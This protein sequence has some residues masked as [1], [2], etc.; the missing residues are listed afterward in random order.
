MTTRGLCRWIALAL[1]ACLA[2]GVRGNSIRSSTSF[3][4]P[5]FGSSNSL[6]LTT[7]VTD[8][9]DLHFATVLAGSPPLDAIAIK[10]H[11]SRC[12]R[13][14]P[15][16]SCPTQD[17][18]PA[19]ASTV[20]VRRAQKV[21]R[22]IRGLRPNSTYDVY[23]VAEVPQSNGVFGSVLNVRGTTTHPEPPSV[24]TT[25]AVAANGSAHAV[26]VDVSLKS[27]GVV[28][29]ALVPSRDEL[30]SRLAPR[31]VVNRERGNGVISVP[32]Q[33]VTWDDLALRDVT[34]D[35]L[36]S[37]TDYDL[38]VVTEAEGNG[39]VFSEV[40]HHEGALHTHAEAPDIAY[41]TCSPVNGS[42][43]ALRVAV[44]L[45]QRE[46]VLRRISPE[47]LPL[48]NY[49]LEYEVVPSLP[50][51]AVDPK[52]TT[53]RGFFSLGRFSSVEELRRVLTTQQSVFEIDGLDS[54]TSFSVEL[55]AET[56]DSYG[57][58]GPS[59]AAPSCSTHATAPEIQTAT[60]E[61]TNGTVHAL[62][63]QVALH[64]AANVH[65][66]VVGGRVPSVR[67]LVA[68]VANT[69]HLE[70]L[71]RERERGG[72]D[73][74]TGV[75]VAHLDADSSAKG[76]LEIQELTDATAYSVVLFA[77][78][79]GSYGVFSKVFGEVLEATTNANASDVTLYSA[80]PVKGSTNSVELLLSMAKPSDV[81]SYCVAVSGLLHAQTSQTCMEVTATDMRPATL[82]ADCPR[83]G[84]RAFTY[85][86]GNLSEATSY[87]VQLYAES[88]RRNG[89]VSPRTPTLEVSTHNRS[90]EIATASASPAATRTDT[91]TVSVAIE[92]PTPSGWLHFAVQAVGASDDL[93][94]LM[95]EDVARDDDSDSGSGQ[96]AVPS[97]HHH[98][99][100]HHRSP[101]SP[102]TRTVVRHGRLPVYASP[103]RQ[104]LSFP[105]EA[106]AANTTYRVSLTVES[107][108]ADNQRS[109]VFSQV[110]TTNV[111]THAKA[112][113]IILATVDPSPHA[114]DSVVVT[115]NLSAPGIVHFHLSDVE[116][117]DPSII[118]RG[119]L[120]GSAVTAAPHVLRGSFSVEASDIVMEVINGTN[121]T[122]PM[123]PLVFTANVSIDGLKPATTYHVSLT[124]E[125]V[126]S[127]GVFGE[128]PPPIL[129]ATHAPAPRFVAN[130]LSV[131]PVADSSAAISISFQL[132]RLGEVH[133]A[134]FFRGLVDDRWSADERERMKL[135]ALEEELNATDANDTKP[136]WPP[137]R[138]EFEL[139]R[140]TPAML[141]AARLDELGAGVWENG[142][143]TVSRDDV[144]HRKRSE[145]KI[146]KLPPNAVFDVCLVPETAAS[147]GVFHWT[148]PSEGCYR[149]RT[150]AD[151]SNQ[152]VYL[153]EIR[154]EPL[155]GT[156]DGIEI[157]LF[158]SKLLD[159][160]ESTDRP[161]VSPVARLDEATGRLPYVVIID[162]N[163]GRQDFTHNN[164]IDA[165]APAFRHQR[166][167]HPTLAFKHA[168]PGRGNV[169]ASG[170]LTDIAAENATFVTLRRTIRGLQANRRYFVFFAYETIGSD[171]VF[172]KINPHKH[173]PNDTRSENEAI[174]VTTHDMPP[175]L[176]RF[177]AMPTFGNTSRISVKLDVACSSCRQALVHVLVL[178]AGCGAPPAAIL[179]NGEDVPASDDRCSQSIVQRRI[180]VD[181]PERQSHINDF[182]EE[183]DGGLAPNTTYAVF[184]ATETVGSEGV[185]SDRFQGTTVRTFD[186]APGFRFLRVEPRRGTTTELEIEWELERP[187]EVHYMLGKAG[188]PDFNVTS[189]YNVSHKAAVP[190]WVPHP[191]KFHNYDRDIVRM[192]RSV[193]VPRWGERHLEILD[194]LL[195]GTA[196]D[197]FIVV[198]S[199]DDSGIYGEVLSFKDVATLSSAPMLLAHTA[200]PTPASTTSL[201]VGFRVDGPCM[202]HFAVI[203]SS[204]WS[205]TRHV[206][207]LSEGFG[208]RLAMEDRLVQRATIHIDKSRMRRETSGYIDS[209]WQ[210]VNISVPYPG[211]KYT[212]HIVTET[213]HS[214][215]VFG[216]VATHHHVPS[217]SLPPLVHNVSVAPTDARVD[218]LTV[219]ASLSGEGHLHFAALRHGEPF[220]RQ[221]IASFGEVTVEANQTSTTFFIEGLR[222]RTTYDVYLRTETFRSGGVFGD[223]MPFPVSAKTHGLPAEVLEDL[224]CHVTPSCQERG[225]EPCSRV[226]NVCGECMDGHRG[227][228]GH[229]NDPCQRLTG[230]NGASIHSALRI[231]GIRM[232][233]PKAAAVEVSL[234]AD[235]AATSQL[236]AP[237]DSM[238]PIDDVAV[239]PLHAQL[240]GPGQCECE[241]GYQVDEQG[242]AH[243]GSTGVR[244]ELHKTPQRKVT[245]ISMA[246]MWQDV[247]SS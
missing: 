214:E 216:T 229:S 73:V 168:V 172:T 166:S 45:T 238:L 96:Q 105:I 239:C 59:K 15:S 205:L 123:E 178:P 204:P 111:T 160:P 186:V 225:R 127:D 138:S 129:V 99:H 8:A 21:E 19:H 145:K 89:V 20:A 237:L 227:I 91:V 165:H 208:N 203:L 24:E 157:E 222:E 101:H 167:R 39:G 66:L 236:H 170:P 12:T 140:L 210:E 64:Q 33:Q 97:H 75:F 51:G 213:E 2:G 5:T 132:E 223:W 197:L 161:G 128:F 241:D 35:G 190:S 149:V 80:T 29:I 88:E 175:V 200:F 102:S 48:H 116:F 134:V 245:K 58:R 142:T 7:Y 232:N 224:E 217:H 55:V 30:A 118:K 27:P 100:H 231:R 135:L 115:T 164:I 235:T 195:A 79:T 136:V 23:I 220:S 152:S 192:R 174:Q 189:P 68:Q 199:D 95:A 151:Y 187:G 98:H 150:H 228:E 121:E 114:I 56:R 74:K 191:P 81:L 3:V 77:E 198:E 38:L 226:S 196:Y 87:G 163:D 93:P 6:S 230:P 1:A 28:H 193:R 246:P 183:I 9:A 221:A 126:G 215:G 155:R 173:R 212:V 69:S 94:A 180:L 244:G 47:T 125:T 156:T 85:V 17:G 18:G 211:T 147:D 67:Q 11:A 22:Q 158:V 108:G 104:E 177:E 110:Q 144:V 130:T 78:T 181:M 242:T 71:I 133:Y 182:R 10:Q 219:N 53:R 209:G 137:V 234:H 124:T 207:D 86:V 188:N 103:Q 92:G 154:V 70:Q 113:R 14:D 119:G 82:P 106:L 159:A 202:V 62:T 139:H 120:S 247:D 41:A 233:R 184:F 169:V 42:A 63:L 201:T 112:P 240:V 171:G 49:V 26:V 131:A 72:V 40:V 179:S 13:A 4:A 109:G 117:A 37:A 16:G 31:D 46:D 76:S 146:E 83:P 52:P 90:A 148:S 43:S 141:K 57:V 50:P 185:V 153:D 107:A 122:K 162:G 44:Q 176:K 65:Y 54:G 25:R 206:A 243:A 34:V 84:D 194:H 61:A 32:P 143:I 60:L 36:S 218:A